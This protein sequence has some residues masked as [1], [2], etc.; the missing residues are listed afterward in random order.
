MRSGSP[1]LVLLGRLGASVLALISAPIVARAIGPD[2]R[3][4]T[5]AALALF[6]LVP[7]FLGMGLPLEL[8]RLVSTE[9]HTSMV[10]ASRRLVFATL[11]MSVPFSV[12]F[13]ATIFSSFDPEARMAATVGVALTP[14]MLS[15]ICDVSCMVA[16]R[17]FVGILVLQLLQPMAYLGG[18]TLLWATSWA[19]T[20]SVIWVFIASNVMSFIFGLCRVRAGAK[21]SVTS[22]MSLAKGSVRFAGGALAETASNRLDQVIALPVIGAVE[23]GFYSVSVTVGLAPLAIAQALGASTFSAVANSQGRRRHKLVNETINQVVSLNVVVSLLLIIF[24]PSFVV[25]LFGEAFSGAGP[26]IRVSAFACL[27]AS[28]ALQASSNL[29]AMGRPK[30]LA[31]S[32]LVSLAIGTTS[33]LILGPHYGSLGAAL[34]SALGYATLALLATRFCGASF[35]SVIPS[36]MSFVAGVRTLIP[37]K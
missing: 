30:Q 19:T 24:G 28:I 34:A 33:L 25:L 23:A 22:P 16:K 11:L 2:G 18:V 35:R 1:G 20:A 3:G 8:R 5:A 10:R 27:F 13:G 15:W 4:E 14:L 37:R 21:R 6:A 26:A 9:G 31:G 32:Q 29:V 36:P 7:V 17:D 12:A